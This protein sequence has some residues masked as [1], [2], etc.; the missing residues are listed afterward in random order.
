MEAVTGRDASETSDALS[1]KEIVL[2][3]PSRIDTS[4]E[5]LANTVSTSCSVPFNWHM[6]HDDNVMFSQGVSKLM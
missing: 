1:C 2:M 4:M 6:E 5:A 3:Q